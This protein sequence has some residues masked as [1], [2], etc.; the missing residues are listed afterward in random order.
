MG[1]LG[2]AGGASGQRNDGIDGRGDDRRRRGVTAG[3]AM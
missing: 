2:A 1:S 3:H